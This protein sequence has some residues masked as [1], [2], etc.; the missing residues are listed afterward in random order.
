MT[1]ITTTCTELVLMLIIKISNSISMLAHGIFLG[2]F[3]ISSTIIK[4]SYLSIPTRS[5]KVALRST[6]VIEQGRYI[7]FIFVCTLVSFLELLHLGSVLNV[8]REY[9]SSTI[10]DEEFSLTFIQTDTGDIFVRQVSENTL[11]STG[12]CVPDLD[13]FWMSGNESIEYWIVQNT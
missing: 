8:D 5:K 13:T 1:I 10:T 7:F 6:V 11:E 12:L 4:E 3:F 9:S 2:S